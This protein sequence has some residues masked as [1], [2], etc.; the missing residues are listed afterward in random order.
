MRNFI[1]IVNDSLNEWK[2]KNELTE[3]K[4]LRA[5]NTDG[6]F[7]IWLNPSR[8]QVSDL[9]KRFDLRALA[10]PSDIFV[11]E[12]AESTHWQMEDR[13]RDEFGYDLNDASV[14]AMVISE[15]YGDLAASGVSSHSDDWEP[16]IY[17]DP[18]MQV[19]F[20]D[21][22]GLQYVPVSKLLQQAASA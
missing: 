4:V 3:G 11:W 20:S 1:D 6:R 14:V 9:V 15:P 5:E 22:K 18:Q 19:A 16:E 13:L 17:E 8:N 12:A 2:M 7:N 21:L 10:T